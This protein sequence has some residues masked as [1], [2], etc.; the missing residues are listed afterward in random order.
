MTLTSTGGGTTT[1]GS[2]VRA[3]TSPTTVTVNATTGPN[4]GTITATAKATDPA[5]NDSTGTVTNSHDDHSR[6]PWPDPTGIASANKT[7]GTAGKPR[8][9]DTITVTFSEAIL[10]TSVRRP[11]TSSWHGNG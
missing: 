10:G 3:G 9:G 8:P 2:A 7:G 4:D 6:T 11:R 1:S 5:G